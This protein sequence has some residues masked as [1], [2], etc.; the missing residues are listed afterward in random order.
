MEK[1]LN[2]VGL[3]VMENRIKP[4]TKPTIDQLH[5]AD[6]KTVMITGMFISWQK[7]IFLTLKILY[8]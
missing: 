4:E 8:A 6:I 2:F 7:I 1:D 5:N 3:V